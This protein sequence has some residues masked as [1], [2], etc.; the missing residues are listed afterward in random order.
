MVQRMRF[1][2]DNKKGAKAGK[3]TKRIKGE[4]LG[5]KRPFLGHER[6]STSQ[7]SLSFQLM[8]WGVR[9]VQQEF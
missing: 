8:T 9:D 6:R 7:A 1:Q 5:E 2:R 4:Y 3:K